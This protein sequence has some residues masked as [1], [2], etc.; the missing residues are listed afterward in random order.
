MTAWLRLLRGE[1]RKLVTT[2]MPWAFLGVLVVLAVLNGFAVVSGTDM[3][4]SKKFISTGFDQQSMVAFANNAMMGSALF[5]AIAVAREYSHLTVVPM[6]L[7][8]PRRYRAFLAQLAAVLVGGAVLSVIGAGLVIAAVATALPST[9]YGFLVSAGGVAQVLAAAAY[10]GAVGAALGAGIA[11]VV[12]NVGGAV[13]ATFLILMVLPPLIVQLSSSAAS[14]VPGVLT[15]VASGVATDV[16]T[17]AAYAAL[18]AWGLVPALLGL[19]ILRRR[20]VV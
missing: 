19:L 15:N 18:A 5:G 2:R 9:D 12:R 4:G 6:Y 14:W 11:T 10:A 13:A 16:A 3:D 20:D 8:E 1:L 7:T 17:P